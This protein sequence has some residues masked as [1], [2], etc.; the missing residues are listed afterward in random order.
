VFA[1]LAQLRSKVF[2]LGTLWLVGI[3]ILFSDYDQPFQGGLSYG[4]FWLG[5]LFC[6][7]PVLYLLLDNAFP[8]RGKMLVLFIWGTTLYLPKV[9]RSPYFFNFQDEIM[10]FQNLKLIYEGGTLAINPTIFS[11]S[12]YYPG[13]ELLAVSLKSATGLSLFSTAI[14]LI[15]LVH[16][17][18]PVFIFLAFKRI[19]SSD[20]I[21][22]IGA[23]V[24]TCNTSYI[25]FDSL[26][27]Y[28]S[29]GI[30]FVA[31]L[32]FLVLETYKERARLFSCLIPLVLFALVVTHH[33]S[34]YWFLIFLVILV[35]VQFCDNVIGKKIAPDKSFAYFLLLTA[36]IVFSW[37]IYG[38]PITLEYF[39][40]LFTNRLNNILSFFTSGAQRVLFVHSSLPNYEIFIGYLY[41]PLILLLSAIGVYF[42]RKGKLR[43]TLIYSFILYGPLLTF[44]MIPLILTYGGAEIVYRSLPFL[45]IGVSLVIAYAVNGMIRQR[46]LLVKAFALSAIILI[47]IAGISLRGDD[48]GRFAGS[49]NLVSGPAA[50]TSDV[51]C[52]SNWFEQEFGTYNNLIGDQTVFR[53][54]G[55]YGFQNVT[56]F[57]AWNVFFPKTINSTVTDTLT[58]LNITYIVVDRRITKYLA[59]YGYYFSPVELGMKNH[60]GYGITQPLPE[61]CI[62]K[63]DNTTLVNE[64]YSNGN[65]NIYRINP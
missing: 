6:M 60:P 38:A 53:V 59:K 63:F 36:V 40:G 50:I 39:S 32:V 20:R 43:K 49:S 42:V 2:V 52:A 4:Q 57:D 62:D 3:A 12:T 23:F 26:F 51:V 54:F 45:F 48:S 1:I 22:A 27:S 13:L 31:I 24:F 21:A 33:F 16:S 61:E 35:I 8:W 15:G 11:I 14:L 65:I 29:L 47:A 41:F 58:N 64:I 34:S 25:F 30:L 17:L 46:N 37:Q 28:E 55:G 5:I 9:L 7:I 18:V 56:I 10:H 44:L 19:A